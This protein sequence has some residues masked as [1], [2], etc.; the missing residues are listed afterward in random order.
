M[1]VTASAIRLGSALPISLCLIMG[2]AGL[3]PALANE[4]KGFSG[5]LTLGGAMVPDYEG[6]DDYRPIPFA[7]G[8]LAYDEYYIE[9]RGPKLRANVMPAGM[10]PVGVELGPSLAYRFG[11]DDVKNDRVDDLRDID[12]TIAVGGFVKLYT[13]AVLQ[14]RDQIGFEVEAL[15]GVG[16]DRDGA[17]ISFG[18]FYSFSPWDRLRLGFR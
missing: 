14:E 2:F 3:A 11:R 17:T 13:D 18:P 1:S 5:Y 12:G 16:N 9:A 7:A 15:S 4:T 6:S 10:L 8:R